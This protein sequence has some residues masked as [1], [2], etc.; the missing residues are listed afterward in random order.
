MFNKTIIASGPTL[1]P[2]DPV[3]FISNRSSGKTGF[4]LAMEAKARGIGEI[5]F[6][7]GPTCFIPAGVQVVQVETA[8]E[9]QA[10]V[11]E[12]FASS[13]VTIMA[14]AVSDYRSARVFPEK[15]KKTGEKITLELVQNPDILLDLGQR[16]RP[17]QILVGFAAE[18]E[19]IFVHA[20]EKLIAKNLD[21]L[22]LNEISARNP[23]FGREENQVYFLRPAGMRKIEKTTKA[24]I[25][26]LIWDEIFVL[27]GTAT[28]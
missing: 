22:V 2:I 12:H 4:H 16:K 10:A 26:A 1:E 6:I 24:Q 3:R 7:T 21:V 8:R 27:A 19:D 25:A 11:N 15:M 20:R 14:A 17:E 9:M 28:G 5:V 23:A 18:S 13:A